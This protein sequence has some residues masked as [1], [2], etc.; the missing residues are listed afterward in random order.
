MTLETEG[1]TVLSLWRGEIKVSFGRVSK[2]GDRTR[3]RDVA[4]AV[5]RE[6][7]LTVDD[8][9][10]PS[11]TPGAQRRSVAWPRQESMWRMMKVGKWSTTQVGQFHGGRDHTTC[12]WAV[13]AH[14]KRLDAVEAELVAA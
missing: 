4:E 6:R 10:M 8:L 12:L 2:V 1:R 11:G 5:A 9:L 14:Q 3:M 13:A 7:G